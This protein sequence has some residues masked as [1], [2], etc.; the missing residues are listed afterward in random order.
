M[1][2]IKPKIVVTIIY[3]NIQRSP[4]YNSGFALRFPRITNLRID[5]GI[6]DIATLKEIT[7]DYKR[8]ELKIHY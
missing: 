3:Q 8:H 4:T 6:A 2:Y 1:V 7:Q 5:K